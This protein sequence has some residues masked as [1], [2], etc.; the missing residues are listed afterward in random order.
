MRSHPVVGCYAARRADSTNSRP[1][2]CRPLPW[3]VTCA[4]LCVPAALAG[5]LLLYLPLLLKFHQWEGLHDFWEQ[6]L[7]G[8][9]ACP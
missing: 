5:L 4:A 2:P 7:F 3:N 8:L 1:E 6:W 9:R